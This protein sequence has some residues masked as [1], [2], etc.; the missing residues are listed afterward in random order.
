MRLPKGAYE[1]VKTL[2]QQIQRMS[3][4]AERVAGFPREA[5]PPLENDMKPL[6]GKHNE[7]LSHKEEDVVFSLPAY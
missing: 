6:T 2:R 4:E 3:P 5:S 1:R 7:C